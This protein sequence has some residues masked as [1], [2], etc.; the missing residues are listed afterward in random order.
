MPDVVWEGVF[1][2][3][4]VT[5]VTAVPDCVTVAVDVPVVVAIA[6]ADTDGVVWESPC[7]SNPETRSASSTCWASRALRESAR[8]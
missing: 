5:V 8:A 7:A 1:V 6:V 3:D 4:C 2:P